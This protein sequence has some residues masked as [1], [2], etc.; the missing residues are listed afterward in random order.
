MKKK[1]LFLRNTGI[2]KLLLVED[3]Y[4]G[5]FYAMVAYCAKT[6]CVRLARSRLECPLEVQRSAGFSRHFR[7]VRSDITD[8]RKEEE[9]DD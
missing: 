6:N 1:K 2:L 5:Y 8:E 9:G 7:L 4:S 3:R